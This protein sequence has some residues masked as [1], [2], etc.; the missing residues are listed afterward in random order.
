MNSL[1]DVDVILKRMIELL[2]VGREMDWV[3]AL[4]RVGGKVDGDFSDVSSELISMYGG[5]GSIN[6]VVLHKEGR[7]LVE[8]NNEFD[9]L[10][11]RL[12]EICRRDRYK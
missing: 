6:D 7:A 10:R 4:K 11:E 2:I 8:E 9:L 3:A 12:Y 5:V 1:N